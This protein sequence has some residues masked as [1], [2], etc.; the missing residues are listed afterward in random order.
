MAQVG[1]ELV[2]DGEPA[3]RAAGAHSGTALAD[4]TVLTTAPCSQQHLGRLG[5]ARLPG[6]ASTTSPAED[7]AGADGTGGA[8]ALVQHD[9]AEQGRGERLCKDDRR[10]LRGVE[11][12]QAAGEENVG[13]RGR[14]DPR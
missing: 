10:H 7:E 5:A 12:A 4:G 1:G 6:A 9:P 2:D 8:D 13:E 14:D 3:Q 11:V